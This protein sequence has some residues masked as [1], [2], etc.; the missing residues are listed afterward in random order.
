MR[1]PSNSRRVSDTR[2]DIRIN[3]F[4]KQVDIFVVEF[5]K[6]FKILSNVIVTV[7]F[8]FTIALIKLSKSLLSMLQEF[9]NCICG[10]RSR[11]TICRKKHFRS[12]LYN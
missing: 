6:F 10:N 1:V 5:L 12:A 3:R 8:G 4:H 11:D 2:M 9:A 7:S